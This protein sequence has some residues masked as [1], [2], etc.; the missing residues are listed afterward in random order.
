[1]T[2]ARFRPKWIEDVDTLEDYLRRDDGPL[3][4]NATLREV[5][6]RRIRSAIRDGRLAPGEPL[7]ET[8]L[9]EMLGISRTPVREALQ[10]L[11]Q[12]GLAQSESGKPISVATIT[13]QDLLDVVHIRRLLE[14]ELT[15]L[16]AAHIKPRQ[17]EDLEDAMQAMERAA[18]EDDLPAWTR[19]DARFHQAVR[20]ACPNALLGETV[21]QL[22]NRVHSMGNVDTQTNPDRLRECT[23]EHRQVVDAIRSRAET[24]AREA[25]ER[26]LEAL[27][28]SLLKRISYR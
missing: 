3:P 8:A 2:N 21:V 15:R 24:E 23:R 7:K 10:Q 28:N 6:Y 17:L 14:P 18:A 4:K 9:S 19:A 13:I 27:T 26:H 5:A 11:V 20:E 16:A 22:R 1:M 25:V 12:E